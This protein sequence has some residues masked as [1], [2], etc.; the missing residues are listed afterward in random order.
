MT[1]KQKQMLDNYYRSSAYTLDDVYGRYSWRKR[2]A[3]NDIARECVEQGGYGLRVTGACKSNFSVA[4]RYS[5][6][7]VE[8]LVY[9]T[10]VNRF[11]FVI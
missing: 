2:E 11:D 9:H 6:D 5:M 8:H 1:K 4:Y 10:Y 3:Y 7:G